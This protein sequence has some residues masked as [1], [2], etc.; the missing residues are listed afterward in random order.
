MDFTALKN[1]LDHIDKNLIPSLRIA[2]NVDNKNV[3]EYFT[4]REDIYEEEKDKE[5]YYLFSA[6]KVITCAAAMRLYEEGLLDLEAPVSKYLPEFEELYIA[7]EIADCN[8]SI[9]KTTMKKATKTMLV[10]HLMS[11]EGGLTYSLGNPEILK[12]KE[13]TNNKA[14]TRQIA[15]AIAKM[16]LLFEPGENYSYSL[17]HD[18]LAAVIEVV[19]QK[20]FGEYL[21]EVIFD[22]LGMKDTFFLPDENQLK[23]MHKQF[24]VLPEKSVAVEHEPRCIYALSECHESGGAGMVSTKDDYLKFASCLANGASPDG[25][26]LL[27]PETIKK[28]T[29]SHLGSYSDTFLKTWKPGYTYALGVRVLVDPAAAHSLSPVGEFGWDGAAGCYTLIDP[30]KKVSCIFTMHVLGCGYCYSTVHPTIRNLIYECIE[31]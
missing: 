14:T 3:F 28:M 2:V 22:P 10:R 9:D 17:C 21:H 31:K 15:S 5:L 19:A 26:V 12:I 7:N 20:S 4:A 13:E 30:S 6:S 24:S 25:Y 18:V 11:M 16:P 23:R 27:K 8:R 29:T 1:Y